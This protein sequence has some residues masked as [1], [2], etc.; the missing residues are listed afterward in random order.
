MGLARINLYKNHEQNDGHIHNIFTEWSKDFTF[1]NNFAFTINTIFLFCF[2]RVITES[3]YISN[4]SGSLSKIRV[5]LD[6]SFYYISC[7]NTQFSK[8]W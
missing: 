3:R 6:L 7:L 4:E 1:Y 8:T 2:I 5:S